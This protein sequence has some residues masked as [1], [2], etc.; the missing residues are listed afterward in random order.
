MHCLHWHKTLNIEVLIPVSCI[1][2]Q[3]HLHPSLI[4]SGDSL[5]ELS[6]HGVTG[7]LSLTHCE[8]STYVFIA[9]AL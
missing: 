1:I 2:K 9:V 5:S 3:E 4:T 8:G 6:V 7:S